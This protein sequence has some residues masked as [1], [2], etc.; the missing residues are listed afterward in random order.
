MGAPEIKAKKEKGRHQAAQGK[1]HK[2]YGNQTAAYAQSSRGRISKA[3]GPDS[4]HRL[5][6][7]LKE[8]Y[9]VDATNANEYTAGA[10][11]AAKEAGV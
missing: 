9:T 1:T 6:E 5:Y 2:L 10:L 7:L 4:K 8:R 3:P 11:R